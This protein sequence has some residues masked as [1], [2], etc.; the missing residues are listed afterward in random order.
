MRRARSLP[1]D[2][3]SCGATL[4]AGPGAPGLLLEGVPPGKPLLRGWLHL[5]A[6]VAMLAI[7][8]MV[9]LGAHNGVERTELVVY[10][11]SLV[12]LFG[13]SA[14]YHRL[15]WAAAPRRVLKRLDHSTIF[16][17]IAGTYTAVAGLSLHG[18]A[19][20]LVLG[21]VWGGAAIGITIRQRWL[22]APSWVVGLPYLITGWCA[23][24]VL[25]Q[26]ARGLGGPGFVLV[27]A[28]GLAY[29]VGAAVYA[30]RRPDPWPRTFGFHELFHTCTILGAGLQLI[31]VAFFALPRS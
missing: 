10:A 27:L 23:L 13:V 6:F 8:P 1:P 29:S 21:L 31:A 12:C 26:L 14:A 5:G 3:A 7:G 28:G 18:W 9:V 25:P 20:A 19:Q 17:A 2:V 22:D 4:D 11:T 24:A 15:N 16:L 30:A